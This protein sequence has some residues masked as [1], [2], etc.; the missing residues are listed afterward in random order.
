MISAVDDIPAPAG[1]GTGGKVYGFEACV[2]LSKE[3]PDAATNTPDTY[4]LF[5]QA[6][7]LHKMDWS[8][9]GIAQSSS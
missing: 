2:A 3:N 4:A 1:T 5:A 6:M 9:G 8:D 7:Y